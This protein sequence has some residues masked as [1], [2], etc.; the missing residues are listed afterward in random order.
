MAL[1]L[2]NF[3]PFVHVNLLVDTPEA[4]MLGNYMFAKVVEK[5]GTLDILVNNAGKWLG[6][7]NRPILRPAWGRK[8]SCNGI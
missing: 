3:V 6:V 1:H 7:K 5:F 8:A 4:Q 2:K